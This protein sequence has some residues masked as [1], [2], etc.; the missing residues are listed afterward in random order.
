M[1]TGKQALALLQTAAGVIP[2]PL[3]QDAIG[4][5]MKII[6][7]CEVSRI[8]H[9]KTTKTVY[10]CVYQEA[11]AVQKQV[12]LLQERVT[13]LMIVIVDNVTVQFE[14]GNEVVKKAVQ[15]IEKD[16]QDFL[17]YASCALN[18]QFLS[19]VCYIALW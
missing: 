19:T 1:A 12:K 16:V 14:E 8:L 2:V 7:V 17:G 3:L 13:H 18:S 4:V 11:S 10:L 5:A 9:E 15:G 6:E